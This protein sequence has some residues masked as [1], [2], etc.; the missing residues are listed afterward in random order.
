MAQRVVYF[1][2]FIGTQETLLVSVSAL[3]NDNDAYNHM[4]KMSAKMY[5]ALSS[6][7]K[8][9]LMVPPKFVVIER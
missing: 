4:Q 5:V 3:I 7:V 6:F 1:T 2:I 9:D 8:D